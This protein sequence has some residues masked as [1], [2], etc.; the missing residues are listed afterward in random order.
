MLDYLF[1][2][3]LV[4]VACLD[5]LFLVALP[6]FISCFIMFVVTIIFLRV[7]V[8]C[9][10]ALIF[11]FCVLFGGCFLLVLCLLFTLLLLISVFVLLAILFYVF[12]DAYF[13][14]CLWLILVIIGWGVV[15]SFIGLVSLLVW[16]C[17]LWL[18]LVCC[19]LWFV[20]DSWFALLYCL[21][22]V[23]CLGIF[24]TA[25]VLLRGFGLADL[26]ILC[27]AYCLVFIVWFGAC[28]F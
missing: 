14:A 19:S 18:F 22:V 21:W 4:W 11:W 28:Y 5:C 8:V 6:L 20:F 23:I 12:N 9:L 7:L 25:I 17:W 16:V 2:V 13:Y 15:I 24:V 26:L 3:D 27:I 10:I 1:A